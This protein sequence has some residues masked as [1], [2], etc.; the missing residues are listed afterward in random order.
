MRII[1][2]TPEP[3]ERE[4]VHAPLDDSVALQVAV[5]RQHAREIGIVDERRTASEVDVAAVDDPDSR[6]TAVRAAAGAGDLRSGLLQIANLR[7]REDGR[8]GDD[9]PAEQPLAG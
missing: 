4:W 3:G 1:A 9:E 7:E 2:A 5:E 8:I 6:A